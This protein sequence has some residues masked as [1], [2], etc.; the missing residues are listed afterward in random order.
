MID[1]T[2]GA[3]VGTD[4]TVFDL[5]PNPTTQQAAQTVAALALCRSCPILEACRDRALQTCVWGMVQGGL[6][7]P[8]LIDADRARRNWWRVS[9]ARVTA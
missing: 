5:H 2:T 1:W 6:A 3:C 7:R 8:N 4:P 9:R